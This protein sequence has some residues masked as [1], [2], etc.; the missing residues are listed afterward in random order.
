MYFETVDGTPL[1]N[2]KQGRVQGSLLWLYLHLP[3]T[4]GITAAS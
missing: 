1:Q 2:T 4:I 3:L